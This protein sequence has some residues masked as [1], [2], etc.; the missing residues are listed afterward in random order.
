[1]NQKARFNRDMET[2]PFTREYATNRL[3]VYGSTNA[4]RVYHKE[5]RMNSKRMFQIA[6]GEEIL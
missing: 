1:M 3:V 4:C 2:R 6:L 5:V